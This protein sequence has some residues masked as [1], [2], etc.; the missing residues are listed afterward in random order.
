MF[1]KKRGQAAILM[2]LC[3]VGIISL[4]AVVVDTGRIY[5]EHTKL[6]K[7]VD[8]AVLAAAQELPPGKNLSENDIKDI[9]YKA[10]DYNLNTAE[11]TVTKKDNVTDYLLPSDEVKEE[12]AIKKDKYTIE[13]AAVDIQFLVPADAIEKQETVISV[14]IHK[15]LDTR[16][17]TILGYKEWTISAQRIARNGPIGS[18]PEFMPIAIISKMDI[19]NMPKKIPYRTTIR[20]SNTTHSL[21]NTNPL[22]EYVPIATFNGITSLN[23]IAEKFL[24]GVKGSSIKISNTPNVIETRIKNREESMRVFSSMC[25]GLEQRL[26][27]GPAGHGT[28]GCINSDEII[29][30]GDKPYNIT[31]VD[32]NYRFSYGDDPRLVLLPIVQTTNGTYN[33]LSTRQ[34]SF[35]IIGFAMF[36]IQYAH[37]TSYPP[38]GEL[39]ENGESV[40]MTELVGFF[41]DSIIEGPIA[42]EGF[43]YGLTGVQFVDPND[44]NVFDIHI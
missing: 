41:T 38:G 20:L 28:I 6:Q 10:L 3:L 16:L 29:L 27:S 25:T 39:F 12:V 36:Y 42:P 34:R 1:S 23:G 30:A 7:A 17:S 37:Y 11:I 5:V 15:K 44:E 26:T 2:T 9:V 24:H 8:S 43:D 31:S 14:T 35:K 19:N 4:L 32:T 33:T 40:A 22:Y 13:N 21:S 18:V